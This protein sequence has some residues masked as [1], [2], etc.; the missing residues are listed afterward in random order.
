MD[1]QKICFNRVEDFFAECGAQTEIALTQLST[2]PLDFRST[3]VDL[4]G[5]R[6]EWNRVGARFRTREVYSG[7]GLMFGWAYRG[8]SE[9]KCF[10]HRMRFDEAVVWPLDE[11]LDFVVPTGLDTLIILVDQD[12]IDLLGWRIHRLLW[13]QVPTRH[14]I[15]LKRLCRAATAVALHSRG[16]ATEPGRDSNGFSGAIWRDRILAALEPALVPWLTPPA[17]SGR[18]SERVCRNHLI[19]REVE[20]LL[21]EA[22]ADQQIG[23]DGL[24]EASGIPRRTL[25][26][27]FRQSLGVG[28]L[29][30]LKIVR[31]HQLR[32]SLLA[33][34]AQTSSVVHLAMDL[35]FTHMGRL[36]AD[37]RK[38]FGEYPSDTLRRQ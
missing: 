3:Q 10:G 7:P 16:T 13:R 34:S 30:Y 27:A 36:S 17:D 1:I 15:E 11:E 31:L 35:G 18:R 38:H 5:V 12:L 19:V 2:G 6:L 14:L 32:A 28:P 29:A 4:G 25:F 33:A 26:H 9:V 24:A 21:L 8:P 23:A 20:Q 22:D 37:Y